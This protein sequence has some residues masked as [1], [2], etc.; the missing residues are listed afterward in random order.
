MN[1]R[2]KSILLI[3][4]ALVSLLIVSTAYASKPVQGAGTFY[5]NDDPIINSVRQADGNMIIN[6]T[7][8]FDYDGTIVGSSI[9]DVT[10]LAKPTSETVCH[11][12]ET[13]TGSL[14]GKS[15]TFVF[16]VTVKVDETGQIKGQWTILEGTS[17][18]A[19]LHGSG[20]VAGTVDDGT[21]TL[22]YHFDPN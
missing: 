1:T 22:N 14:E 2:S 10:C 13:F 15:G 3:A 18:L 8:S 17:E 7:L 16:Q 12:R 21:Y 5:L 20:T 9:A 11:G 4:L 19:A 6:Q